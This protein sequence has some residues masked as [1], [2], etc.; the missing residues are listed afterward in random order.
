MAIEDYL[1]PEVGVAVAVSAVVFSPPVRRVVRR[2]AVFGLAGIMMAGDALTTLVGGIGRGVRQVTPALATAD[3]AAGAG[4]VPTETPAPL[5]APSIAQEPSEEPST[6]GT[7]KP[8]ARARM[9]GA[10]E[11]SH[12]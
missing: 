1:D 8:K 12:E 4:A 7:T 10:T 11:G 6:A 5:P 2:G 3:A 9:A